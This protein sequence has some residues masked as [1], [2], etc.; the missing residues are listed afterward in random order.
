MFAVGD[1]VILLAFE[2]VLQVYVF[3]PPAVKLTEP[4]AHSALLPVIATSGKVFTVTAKVAVL[5]EQP[6]KLVPV[7]L[8]V[9]FA[10]GDTVILLAFEA[11]LQVYVFAPPAVKLTEPPAHSALLPVIATIGKVFTVTASVAVLPPKQP[12]ALL[13]VKL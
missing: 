8:Y 9:V 13:P 7:K 6:S 2:A 4:P 11:V 3:A 12:K 10:V 1:T 5:P